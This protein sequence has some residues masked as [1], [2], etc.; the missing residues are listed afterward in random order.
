MQTD[1][2]YRALGSTGERVSAIGL[3]GWHL[4]LPQVD[5]ALSLRITRTAIN[6][7]VNVLDNCCDYNDGASEIRI[8]S[9]PAVNLMPVGGAAADVRSLLALIVRRDPALMC[10]GART[11]ESGRHNRIKPAWQQRLSAPLQ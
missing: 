11:R 6:R 8:S 2:P 5:E 1:I 4:G 9:S 3:G 10:H 7:G